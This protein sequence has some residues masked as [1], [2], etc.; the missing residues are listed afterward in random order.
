MICV[1]FVR[2]ERIFEISNCGLM[3]VWS[4][5]Q[6]I[7]TELRAMWRTINPIRI[8]SIWWWYTKHLK[9]IKPL[10][11]RGP[12]REIFTNNEMFANDFLG[13][14]VVFDRTLVITSGT[15]YHVRISVS[16]MSIGFLA[17]IKWC[18]DETNDSTPYLHVRYTFSN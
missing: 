13:N 7:S 10:N 18:F 14:R 8:W 17:Q 11:R 4:K 12:V 3:V 15:T 6:S 16:V 5:N 9:A 2:I 1:C